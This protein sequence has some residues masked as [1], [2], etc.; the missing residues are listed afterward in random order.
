M[1]SRILLIDSRINDSD[2]FVTSAIQSVSPIVYNYN[3]YSYADIINYIPIGTF[4]SLAIVAHADFG[5]K[6]SFLENEEFF[7]IDKNIDPEFSSLNTF[8]KFLQNITYKTNIKYIDFLGCALASSPIWIDI[9]NHIMTSIPGLI[10]RASTDNTGNLVSD[11]WVL[12]LGSVDAK[13]LYFTD[14]ISNYI[15]SLV[16]ITSIPTN[17]ATGT[18]GNIPIT[19]LNSTTEATRAT[20]VQTFSST[21][22]N[23]LSIISSGT[24]PTINSTIWSGGNVIRYN[25]FNAPINSYCIY[26]SPVIDYTSDIHKLSFYFSHNS[27]SSGI[28]K[29]E[30]YLLDASSIPSNPPILNTPI[31]SYSRYLSTATTN[32]N[33]TLKEIFIPS[34]FSKYYIAFKFISQYGHNMYVDNISFSK[35]LAIDAIPTGPTINSI[36]YTGRTGI[37]QIN[38]NQPVNNTY[39]ISRYYAQYSTSEDFSNPIN[40]GSI[41]NTSTGNISLTL[42]NIYFTNSSI[43]MRIIVGSG[44]SLANTPG[45]SDS[46]NVYKVGDSYFTSVDTVTS[47]STPSITSVTFNSNNGIDIS[48][49]QTSIGI[50]V[51]SRYYI[52]YSSNADFS[53]SLYTFINTT[54]NIGSNILNFIPTI[55]LQNSTIYIKVI[56]YNGIS[57]ASINPIESSSIDF[58]NISSISN[59]NL[60]NNNINNLTISSLNNNGIYNL[61]TNFNGYK[62]L[63]YQSDIITQSIDNVNYLIPLNARN[64][65]YNGGQKIVSVTCGTFHT[66]ILLADG[67]IRTFGRNVYGQLGN[68]NNTNSRVPI[69][70][71]GIS[72]AIAIACGYEHTAVLLA[73]GTIK[74]FG[75]NINGQLGN[76]NNTDSNIPVT[77][78]GISNAIAI[79]C[80]FYHTAILLADGSI[81]T[82]GYN[83][84]GQLGNGTITSSNIPIPVTG[85]SNAIAI[86]C[87]I[88][89]TV[90]L[91]ANGTVQIFGDNT[92]G[93]LGNGNNNI[94]SNV[95]ISIPGISNVIGIASGGQF[96]VLLLADGTLRS[97]GRNSNGQLGNNTIIGNSN[98]PVIVSDISNAIS[99]ACGDFHT[100]VLLADG[101]LRSFGRNSEGQLGIGNQISS[102]IPVNVSDISNA[103][104]VSGGN[105][106]T[107]VLLSDGSVRTF[108]S[109]TE[110]QLGTGGPLTFSSIPVAIT[111]IQYIPTSSITI[112]PYSIN[113][114][115]NRLNIP[116][117][118]DTTVT[119]V[120]QPIDTIPTGPTITS[121]SYS[122]NTGILE[123][124]VDQ[125]VNNTYGISRYYAQYSTSA[126][127]SNLINL[128]SINS[129]SIGN[130]SLTLNNIY[131]TNPTIYLR[132]I[133][134][135]GYSLA[136]TPST[137]DSLNVYK[138]GDSYTASVDAVT[139]AATP[140]IISVIFNTNN[141]VDIV[142]QQSS[143]GT[144]AISRYY[145]QYSSNADFSSSTYKIINSTP[146]IGSNSFTITP[147][148]ANTNL[149]IKI[150]AYN[151]VSGAAS[152]PTSSDTFNFYN[153]SSTYTTVL[154]SNIF[155]NITVTTNNTNSLVN[156]KTQIPGYKLFPYQ[157]DIITQ[158]INNTKYLIPI[159]TKEW[160]YNSGQKVVSIGYN[161]SGL[162]TILLLAD[163]SVKTFGYNSKGQLGNAAT[164]DSGIPV[165]VSDIT[166]A[167]NISC[168]FEHTAIILADGSIKTFGSNIFGQLGNSTTTNSSIPV[169]I[170]DITNA[171]AVSC[172]YLHTAVLLADGSIK[173]FGYNGN[174][175]LGNNTRTNSNIPVTVSGINN[176]IGVACGDRYTAVLL[177]DG[178]VKTFGNNNIIP[179]T[180]PDITNAIAI[181]SS[182][183]HTAVL[184]A[185]GSVKTFGTN[186][187]GQLGNGT[188]TASNIPVTV[189][190]ITTAIGVSCGW[191]HTAVLL[192]DGSIKTFGSNEFGQL[193]NDTT[194][195]SSTPVTVSGINNAISIS[196]GINHT[197]VLLADGSIKTFGRNDFG[198]LGNGTTTNSSTPISVTGIQYIPTSSLPIQNYNVE[199][200]I[201][202]LG[203]PIT[204]VNMNNVFPCLLGH[205][206]VLTP[207]GL[208]KISELSTGDNVITSTGKTVPIKMYS[209]T[210]I[211][212]P[213]TA[214]YKFK[215]N[216]IAKGYPSSSF[217]ISPTH[218][219]A[220]PGG[221]IIPKYAHLSGVKAKQTHIGEEITY[222]HIELPNYLN[223]NLVLDCGAV[224]ESFGA[225]WL[226]TQPK[227]TVVYTF[228]HANKLFERPTAKHSTKSLS[229]Q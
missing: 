178:S 70:V 48:I 141:G 101:T 161:G 206:K 186:M 75:R 177:A 104:A 62:L 9:F 143:L 77:V 56:S 136:N 83:F 78:S 24:A 125:P 228:N 109:N 200:S 225:T 166:N 158:S 99:V 167:I 201:N 37:L 32:A 23:Y 87:T 150:V 39:G 15:G 226:S 35:L 30:V 49:Q 202:R 110:G 176:A 28:D 100:I 54:P 175:Q 195:D 45:T 60:P 118:S 229:K 224:V 193:G 126:D 148:F 97:F 19:T 12:E 79:D 162:H 164:T 20:W 179:V 116:I 168:G 57:G 21:T 207:T 98:V 174:Y 215:A 53:S 17:T 52:Q 170:T 13:A 140:S 58:Y 208:C 222:Y 173:T 112:K 144:P 138:I 18:T 86:N 132:I 188:T 123:I 153:T 117:T 74:T 134:G 149:Y 34:T 187:F 203:I 69:T 46:L 130:I 155:N 157:S 67:S 61:N 129:T 137:S 31:A 115:I 6:V 43:Y 146:N 121:I 113:T 171:V 111:G 8:I 91:L 44:Y 90:V 27:L 7:I 191:Y 198:Q 103:I 219:I 36:T 131:F 220:A 106:H 223:D 85:I 216:S 128:G 122:I 10:V 73:D 163:G 42:N 84:N 96:T 185:D 2:I 217:E 29:L 152:L 213:E 108:G 205:T 22:T 218:A 25:S 40:L 181:A 194:S 26:L 160:I 51:I 204:S 154:S 197:I 63:P 212:T 142:V 94:Q 211:T 3:T 93:Q 227:G 33:M 210:L 14:S 1:S 124:N 159:N 209:S 156:I 89:N 120:P 64:W 41:N 66:A 180:V 50:P 214:P 95:P 190:G 165:N 88:G 221:W 172:G 72:N 92:F 80:G 189:S 114:S 139:S 38:A 47:A 59:I 82:F 102:N 199:T 184:L 192:A 183:Y 169:S 16:D 105:R 76:G 145:I 4:D 55:Q 151:G 81:R 119:V 147:L 196:C 133:A 65:T 182:Y 135:S 11:N 127:F 71:S 5:P 68:G 107:T